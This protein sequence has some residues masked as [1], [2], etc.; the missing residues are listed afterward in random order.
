MEI[1]FCSHHLLA[2]DNTLINEQDDIKNRAEENVV[3]IIERIRDLEKEKNEY[4]EP[5]GTVTKDNI[6]EI[7]RYSKIPVVKKSTRWE[8]FAEGVLRK[9]KNKSGLIYDEN[10]KGWVRRFQKQQIKMNEEQANIVHEFK[11]NE[12]CYEDPFEKKEEEK[13]IRKMKQKVREMRNKFEQQ[14]V[15]TEDVRYIQRQKRKRF[16]LVSNLKMAQ[17]S[18]STFGRK[19]KKFK[20]EK[21]LNVKQHVI[22]QKCENRKIKEEITQNTKLASLVLKTT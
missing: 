6:F 20:K 4:G 21:Q 16:D 11:Q 2:Y 19:D 7:P 13:E 3:R 10:T 1:E 8:A 22:K 14:G 18:S 5:I 12:N 17:T 15:S 9:K